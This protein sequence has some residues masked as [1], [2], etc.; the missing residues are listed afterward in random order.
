[1]EAKSN[2]E[3]MHPLDPLTPAEIAVA[4]ALIKSRNPENSVHFKNITLIEPPKKELRKFLAAERNGSPISN[5]LARRVSALYY[6]RGTADLFVATIDLGT[7]KVEQMDKLDSRYK[8]QAD[9][10]EA[11]DVRDKCLTHPAVIQRIQNYG[12]PDNFTVVCDTWPY[13]RDT[14]ELNRRLAQVCSHSALQFDLLSYEKMY[15]L[16]CF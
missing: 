4:A 8:G 12:L 3:I 16:H 11:V 13:G 9:M 10:D 15:H 7:S 2:T 14:A 1:M 5:T 6:R